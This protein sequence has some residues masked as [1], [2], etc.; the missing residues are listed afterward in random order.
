MPTILG[1]RML[2]LLLFLSM[3]VFAQ[4]TPIDAAGTQVST[5]ESPLQWFI[6]YNMKKGWY[7]VTAPI[8]T[9][10][11]RAAGNGRWIVPLGGGVGRIMKVGFQPVNISAQFY[12]NAVYPLGTSSWCM[13][14]S[15]ALLFPR[16]SNDQRKELL[17]KALKQM[18]QE[19]P[20]K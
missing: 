11:W 3:P 14:L 8:V 19:P 6:N 13:K 10:N 4:D 18:E 1:L 2:A 15:I 20:Q 16:L 9:A 7:L 17:E 5:E 12:G